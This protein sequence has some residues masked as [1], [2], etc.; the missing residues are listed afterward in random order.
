MGLTGNAGGRVTGRLSL[1]PSGRTLLLVTL[2]LVTLS[3]A[4]GSGSK[5]ADRDDSAPGPDGMPV[6]REITASAGIRFRHDSGRT[7]QHYTPETMGSGVAVIDYDGDGLMDL[8]F[9][10]SGPIL[11][12][13]QAGSGPEGS[14]APRSGSRRPAA[15]IRDGGGNRLYRNLG[16]LR[17]EDVTERAKVAG[18]GYGMGAAVG[19]YDADGRQDLYVTCFGPNLLYRNNGDGTFADV[20]LAANVDDPRWSTGAAFTDVDGDGRL[21]LFVQNYLDYTLATHRPCFANGKLVY[22]TPDLA[23]GV[24]SSLFRNRGDGTFED[25]SSVSGI[26]RVLGKGLAVCIADLD[27]DGRPDIYGANDL[28]YNFLFKNLDGRRFEEI[29]SESGAGYSEEGREEAGMGA[30]AADIDDDGRPDLIVSNFQN[31]T[32]AIYR[33]EGN[34]AFTE[35]SRATGTAETDRLGFGIRFFDFDNDGIQD[36]IVANGHIYENA[37]DLDTK[38]LYAQPPSLYRGLGH[39]RFMEVTQRAGTRFRLPRVGRGLALADL[40]ND[41]DL[42]VVFTTN[43]GPAAV[44][45]NVGGNAKSWTAIRL[46]GT[47]RDSTAI[48]ARVT[49]ESGGRVQSQEVRSGCSYLSQSDLRLV[50]GLGASKTIDRL[51]VRWPNGRTEEARGVPARRHLTFVE[52]RGLQP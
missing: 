20:T 25:V 19:D 36:I 39:G 42:D 13:G 28:V 22:C 37:S 47:H 14:R 3:S 35:I 52:G 40:D 12:G 7:P 46:V 16:A 51:V 4:C 32:N 24:P 11:S 17:F 10:D 33:N 5:P 26:D 21:D 15:A 2:F 27:D 31:E 6:F 30:D 23:R 8:Y 9:V 49:V 34:L 44:F 29:G 43:G 38:D 45:E 18:R 48:G 50:F 1:F 41:G